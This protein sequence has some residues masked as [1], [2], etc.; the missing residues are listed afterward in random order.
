MRDELREQRNYWD[1]EAEAFDAIYGGTNGA[2]RKFLDRTFRRDMYE[3]FNF[4]MANCEPVEGRTFL[5]VG[6]G[7]G[8]YSVE[9]AKKGAKL[10]TGLDIA[11]NMLDLS[12]RRAER[13]GVAARCAFVHSDLLAFAADRQYDVTIGIGL[14]DYLRDAGPVLAAMRRVTGGSVIL[15]F[16]RLWTWRAPLRKIRLTVRNCSV[17]FYTRA[18]VTTLLHAAGFAHISVTRVGKLHCVVAS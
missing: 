18:R 9:L 10:V 5:D 17:F 1:R 8:V 11:E 3:R 13:E 2:V 16:P 15:S 6:C 14:F 7:S 12:R 4:T